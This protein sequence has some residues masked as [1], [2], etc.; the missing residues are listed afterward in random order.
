MTVSPMGALVSDDIG[1]R[2]RES[3][4]FRAGCDRLADFEHLARFVIVRRAELGLTQEDLAGRMG[5]TVWTVSRIE[6]GQ[7]PTSSRCLQ[8]LAEALGGQG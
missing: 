8:R 3:A 5:S 6:S 1:C 4:A 2:R 7:D